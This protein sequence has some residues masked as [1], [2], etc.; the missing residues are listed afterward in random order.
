MRADA[1]DKSAFPVK[2][3]GRSYQIMALPFCRHYNI[4][5]KYTHKFVRPEIA[6]DGQLVLDLANTIRIS[7]RQRTKPGRKEV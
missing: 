2:P 6:E 3:S 4:L 5:I 1:K 7:R